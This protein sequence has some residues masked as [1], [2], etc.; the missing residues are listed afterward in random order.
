MELKKVQAVKDWPK[1]TNVKEVQSFL[2]FANYY[3]R[4][5]KGFGGIA[6]PLTEFTR[7]GKEFQWDEGARK[8]FEALKEHI[9][10][11]PVLATFDPDRPIELETDTSNYTLGGQIGQQDNEGKLHP[12]AFYLKKLYRPELNYLIYD[13]EFLAIINA[14]KE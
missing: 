6:A 12:V 3:R 10:S 9:L 13:K 8:S 11:E 4:F 1:P 14:F 7:K 2:G 5:I